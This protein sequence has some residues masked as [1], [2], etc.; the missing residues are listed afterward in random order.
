MYFSI[1]VH[2]E[3]NSLGGIVCPA[4]V[5]QCEQEESCSRLTHIWPR[6]QQKSLSKLQGSEQSIFHNVHRLAAIDSFT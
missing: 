3:K 1:S 5:P 2:W 4:Q 6:T